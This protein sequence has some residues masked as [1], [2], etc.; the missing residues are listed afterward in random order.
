[1]AWYHQATCHCL[2]ANVDPDICLHIVSIGHNKL[3]QLIE[4]SNLCLNILMLTSDTETEIF[5]NN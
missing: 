2:G 3:I 5:R 1:M 4:T